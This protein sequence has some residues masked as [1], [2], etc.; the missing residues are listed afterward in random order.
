MT[1]ARVSLIDFESKEATK[2][3]ARKSEQRKKKDFSKERET[4]KNVKSCKRKSETKKIL[5]N[6]LGL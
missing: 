5:Q 1:F 2:R 6:L 4:I 3:V